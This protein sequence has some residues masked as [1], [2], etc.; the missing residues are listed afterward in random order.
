MSRPGR[1]TP[2]LTLSR[3]EEQTL[4]Q[5]ASSTNT[6]RARALSLRAAIVLA[7]ADGATIAATSERLQVS[8][9]TVGKWR[10]RFL[11]RRLDGLLDRARSGV[12]NTIDDDL[13]AQIVDAGRHTAA[14][15]GT[16]W[17]TR[18]L[19][20][21]LGISQSSVQRIWAAHGVEP[22]RGQASSATTTAARPARATTT[23]A[24]AGRR[25]PD[26]IRRALLKAAEDVTAREGRA[27][28]FH[29]IAREAGVARSVLY[30]H[31]PNRTELLKEA[32][33]APFVDFL[34]VF[35][36]M[37][38]AQFENRELS[39]WE[40][41]RTF[42]SG[43][44]KHIDSHRP[45]LGTVFG[46]RSVISNSLKAAFCASVDHTIEEIGQVGIEE[47]RSRNRGI[48]LETIS[49]KIRLVVAL[50]AGISANRDWLIPADDRAWSRDDLLDKLTEFT[51]YGVQNA[52]AR[53]SHTCL[54]GVVS[55]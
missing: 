12:P 19:A 31:F 22:R 14:P 17:S 39:T 26:A 21:S 43:V 4:R 24:P 45:F 8:K 11:D 38:L 53:E 20:R 34:D 47:G 13:T 23:A 2:P 25:N 55:R 16:P 35:R 3:M 18:T 30:R 32:A 7:S 48:P 54:P 52:P 42:I 36:D 27:A 46:E 51:L 41:E 37:C 9:P 28:S 29:D 49:V 40:I 50:V 1:P 33:L 5:W 10:S 15:D 6:P 44:L